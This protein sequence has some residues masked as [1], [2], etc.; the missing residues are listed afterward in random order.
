MDRQAYTE[1][2]KTIDAV[3]AE[4][5]RSTI[6]DG[7]PWFIGRRADFVDLLQLYADFAMG[8]QMERRSARAG[9][10]ASILKGVLA[11]EDWRD[12]RDAWVHLDVESNSNREGFCRTVKRLKEKYGGR[13]D[14]VLDGGRRP[15]RDPGAG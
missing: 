5:H 15:R 11:P 14:E 13:L 4:I 8:R 3:S 7:E 10:L 12:L 2:L 1:L 9:A 6:R